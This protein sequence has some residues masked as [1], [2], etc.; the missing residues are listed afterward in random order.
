MS[1]ISY[2]KHGNGPNNDGKGTK[3]NIILIGFKGS[4]KT[5]IGKGIAKLLKKKFIDLDDIIREIHKRLKGTDLS[6]REI[7][8][9]HG[10]GHFR[11]TEHHAIIKLGKHKNIILATGGGAPVLRKNRQKLKNIGT[12]VFLDVEPGVLFRRMV[13]RGIPP[14]IDAKNPL[15]SFTALFKERKAVYNQLADIIV[16]LKDDPLGKNVE[17]VIQGLCRRER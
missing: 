3:N 17:K 10:K 16:S 1:K 6:I 11:N 13:K 8:Q 14:I 5:S 9:K 12:V 4:G 15:K 2:R 7:Y